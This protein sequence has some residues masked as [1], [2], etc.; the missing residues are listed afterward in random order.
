[1][2][3]LELFIEFLDF[4]KKEINEIYSLKLGNRQFDRIL[5]ELEFKVELFLKTIH[6]F[7]YSCSE[8]EK[9]QLNYF[10]NKM[11]NFQKKIRKQKEKRQLLYLSVFYK[12]EFTE[13]IQNRDIMQTIY[14]FLY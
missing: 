5:K 9:I 3:R 4:I 6:S 12:G 14:E 8:N 13:P 11:R 2:K 7:P 10:K 1:M